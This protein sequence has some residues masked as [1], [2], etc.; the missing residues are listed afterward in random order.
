LKKGKRKR[1]RRRV[2]CCLK[3]YNFFIVDK[4]ASVRACKGLEKLRCLKRR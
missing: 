3:E 4:Y 1:E 2:K